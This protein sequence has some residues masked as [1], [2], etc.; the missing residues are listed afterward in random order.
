MKGSFDANTILELQ[1]TAGNQFVNRLL[2]PRGS[3]V[4]NIAAAER[5]LLSRFRKRMKR[6]FARFRRR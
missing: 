1:R 4:E 2:M 6:L 3:A 5:S